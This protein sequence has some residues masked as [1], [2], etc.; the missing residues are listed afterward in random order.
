M[1]SSAYSRLLLTD[2]NWSETRFQKIILLLNLNNL[3]DMNS[4]ILINQND[5]IS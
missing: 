1:H 2:I 4:T 5:D 3:V